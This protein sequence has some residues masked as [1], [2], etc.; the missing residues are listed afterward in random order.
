MGKEE[1]VGQIKNLSKLIKRF[2]DKDSL[3]KKENKLIMAGGLYAVFMEL[4]GIK[5]DENSRETAYRVAKMML[6][7]RCFSLSQK[8]P[9][10]T[11]FPAQDYDEY[12][13]VKSISY[14]SMCAHHHVT[15]YGKVDIAYHP[16]KVLL[17]LSKFARIVYY[18][19]GKP[20]MQE[21]MTN[22]IANYLYKSLEPIGLVVKVTGSHLCMES[23]GARATG[24]ITVT[25]CL[26]GVIDKSEVAELFR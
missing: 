18:F 23:R 21:G 3:I 6:S 12:V 10:F 4:L 11:L 14:F 13:I 8:P 22:E 17:G 1:I 20:Q 2:I 26:R 7:E 9:E 19:A 24:S 25:Q 5:E 16:N 15:F